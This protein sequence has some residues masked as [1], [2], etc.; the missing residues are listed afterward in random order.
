M[1]ELLHMD[2]MEYMAG[3]EDNAFELACVDP[4][5]GIER[6]K[7]PA[8]KTR[9]SMS[10]EMQNTGLQWD[11]KPTDEYFNELF[12][13]SDNQIIWGANNFELPPTEY[14]CIWDKMQPVSNFSSA[15]YAWISKGIGRP[16]K[17]FPYAWGGLSD[18]VLGRNKKIKSIHPTQ[19]PVALYKWLLANYAKDGDSILDTHLGSASSAIAAY[20]G[21]FDFVG[22]E[23]DRDYFD[24][25]CK[26]F[27]EETAQQ[28]LAL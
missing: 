2:C 20:Y 25:A 8:G 23:L 1:I 9:F 3:L 22:M 14:F 19:K 17:I 6:F 4:P 11:K 10:K 27:D 21:G 16:A 18:G 15:E 13:V 12:R 24:A 5:Y 26:R 28:A 7:K